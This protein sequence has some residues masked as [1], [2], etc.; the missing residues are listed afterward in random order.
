M[1]V[2]FVRCPAV[3]AQTVPIVLDVMPAPHADLCR[4]DGDG[5]GDDG[6]RVGGVRSMRRRTGVRSAGSTDN[7]L[8]T[9]YLH[10]HGVKFRSWIESFSQQRGQSPPES[11]SMVFHRDGRQLV[12][13]RARQ[14]SSFRVCGDGPPPRKIGSDRVSPAQSRDEH[15]QD[16]GPHRC[17]GSV[18]TAVGPRLAPNQS[19]LPALATP[20]PPRFSPAVP[21]LCLP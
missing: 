3:R 21:E 5:G 11:A 13:D 10:L 19:A 9:W 8:I 20:P 17:D 2:V 15:P 18:R 1:R 14:L 12:G 16:D 6:G 4:D 7:D